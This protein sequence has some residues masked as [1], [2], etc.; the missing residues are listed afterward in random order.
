MQGID[1]TV[2]VIISGVASLLGLALIIPI[3]C[4]KGLRTSF[5]TNYILL[6]GFTICEGLGLG[7]VSCEGLKTTFTK[8]INRLGLSTHLSQSCWLED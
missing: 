3:A 1:L 6:F 2:Y 7:V 8:L 4:C 5:P